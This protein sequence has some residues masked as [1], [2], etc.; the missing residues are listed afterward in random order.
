MVQPNNR[1]LTNYVILAS[2]P[3]LTCTETT[4]NGDDNFSDLVEGEQITLTCETTYHGLWGPTQNWTD[5][6]GFIIPATDISSASSTVAYTYVVSKILQFEHFQ[7]VFHVTGPPG[8]LLFDRDQRSHWNNHYNCCF[9]QVAT[10][11]IYCTDF[12]PQLL[13]QVKYPM[14][15]GWA[16]YLTVVTNTLNRYWNNLMG[17][18]TALSE[19]I[20]V[21]G[22]P[23]ALLFD[24]DQRSHWKNHLNC[25]FVWVAAWAFIAQISC[26]RC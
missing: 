15:F 8:A 22:P 10:L 2:D 4:S 20:C 9:V 11:G 5:S 13:A 25:C 14:Q 21:T 17:N 1:H 24:R 6:A 18:W 12:L 19:E 16:S 26:H 23:G 7:T 3:G